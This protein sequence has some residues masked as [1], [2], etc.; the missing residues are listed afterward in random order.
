[1]P[2]SGTTYSEISSAADTVED[3]IADNRQRL[4]RTN[5]EY[6][7]IVSQM[8]AIGTEYGP[9]VAAIDALVASNPNNRAFLFLQA[10]IQQLL[11]DFNAV[12]ADATSKDQL[13]NA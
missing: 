13:V 3:L 9:I 5:S 2:F 8:T 7:T 6:S 10:H 12:K 4:S 11:A 1:M